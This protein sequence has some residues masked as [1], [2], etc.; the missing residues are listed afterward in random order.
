MNKQGIAEAVHAAIGGTKVQAEQAV[1]VM[2]DSIVNT[3]KK[4]DEVSIA[5]LGIFSVKARAAR[6][7]RNPRTGETL[8]VP[9]M[10]VPKFRA[11]KAL[12]DAVK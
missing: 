1:D 6:Q 8:Q 4:G 2:I 11:A 9:A 5:G 10:K 12:K 3:M 7:A